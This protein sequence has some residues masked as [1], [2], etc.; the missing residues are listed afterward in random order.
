MK[1]R[2]LYRIVYIDTTMSAP[3]NAEKIILYVSA[4]SMHD[5][6]TVFHYVHAP[7]VDPIEVRFISENFAELTPPD[8]M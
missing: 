8:T 5:A 6:I 2:N 1:T 3:Y 7:H 4:D